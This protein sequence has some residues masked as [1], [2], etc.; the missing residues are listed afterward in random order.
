[1]ALSSLFKQNDTYRRQRIERDL[2]KSLEPVGPGQA[3]CDVATE[4]EG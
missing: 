4:E 1:M 3:D 2:R